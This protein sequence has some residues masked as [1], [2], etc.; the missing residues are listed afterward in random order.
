MKVSQ[1][2]EIRRLAEVERLSQRQIAQRLRCCWKTVK[3]ALLMQQALS[4]E[5]QV[6]GA[7][8][9]LQVR[10]RTRDL[11]RRLVQIRTAA[12]ISRSIG[13]LVP[14]GPRQGPALDVVP[15]NL[16]WS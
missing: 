4:A 1:W 7:N 8:L 15:A 5:L 2:A 9:D 14:P 16:R 6:K 3:K 12:E 11:E 10:R 13:A